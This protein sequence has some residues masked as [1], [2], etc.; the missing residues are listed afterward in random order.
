MSIPDPVQRVLDDQSAHPERY[1]DVHVGLVARDYLNKPAR[2]LED[3][4]PRVHPYVHRDVT[5]FH[6]RGG[7]ITWHEDYENGEHEPGHLLVRIP[8]D[9]FDSWPLHARFFRVEQYATN[10]F[11][12][13][14]GQDEWEGDFRLADYMVVNR[15]IT[16]W[17]DGK[18]TLL[19]R[20]C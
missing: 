12:C 15:D 1:I 14:L 4:L 19:T 11:A 2:D 10:F 20:Y 3:V 17:G 9:E 18:E 13:A 8:R 16:T 6:E 7:F 5:M